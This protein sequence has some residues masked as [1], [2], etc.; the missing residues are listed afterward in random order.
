MD[1]LSPFLLNIA[2]NYLQRMVLLAESSGHIM[3][4]I[5]HL[6]DNGVGILQNVDDVILFIQDLTMVE[7]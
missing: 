7:T 3:G 4:L 6:I 5:P 2:A 1:P